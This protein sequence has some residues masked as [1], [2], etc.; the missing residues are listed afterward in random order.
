[1]SV[2]TLYDLVQRINQQEA[3]LAKLRQAFE[4]RQAQLTD[5]TR[6]KAD[7]ELQLKQID[8][9]IQRVGNGAKSTPAAVPG[10]TMAAKPSGTK[11]AA[12]STGGATLSQ[13]LIALVQKAQGP[14]TVKEMTEELQRQKYPTKTTNLA[15]M[16]QTRV[17]DLVKKGIFRRAGQQPGVVMAKAAGLPAKTPSAPPAP[18]PKKPS[19]VPLAKAASAGVVPPLGELLEQ[20]LAKSS[21]P[22]K[23]RELAEK[24]LESGYK[25][26]SRDFTNVISV[27]MCKMANVENVPGQ[28]YRLKKSKT[29][30]TGK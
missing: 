4:T 8:V 14:V 6:R 3:E 19:T 10:P 18:T 17:G 25:T 9:E 5:L 11:A 2:A 29:A 22:L 12:K 15:G 23:V 20:L 26:K 21:R 28:G 30:G 27:A 24:A 7:L 1:M 16:I 13:V